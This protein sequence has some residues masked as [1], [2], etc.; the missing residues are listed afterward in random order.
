M[1]DPLGLEQFFPIP[2]PMM[3]IV[4]TD[5]LC[6]I[7]P[8]SIYE[9]LLE[10]LNKLT[11]RIN[12]LIGQCRARGWYSAVGN[13]DEFKQGVEAADG[14]LIPLQ[15][16][17]HFA[18]AGVGLDK[19]IAWFPLDVVVAALKQLVEQR[20]IIKQIIFEVSGMADVMRGQVDPKEKLGQT[21]IKA[22]W[23]GL[24]VQKKQEEVARF[25]RDLFRLKAEVM[26]KKFSM[27]TLLAMTG[28]ELQTQQEKQQIQATIQQVQMAVQAGA[29]PQ[30]Q[31]MQLAEQHKDKLQ[32]L[33]QPS[34]EEV[35]Q[36]L[37]SDTAR[38]YQIDIESDSH[39]RGDVAR[40]QQQMAMFIQGTAAFVGAVG[41]L[42]QQGAM[43]GHIAIE[44]FN[45]FARHYKL[46]KQAEDALD[47]WA[48]ETKNMGAQQKPDPQAEAAKAKA[49]ADKQKARLDVQT[50]QAEH[51]MKMQ[52]MQGEAALGQAKI[53]QEWQRVAMDGQRMQNEMVLAQQQ[54]ALQQQMAPQVVVQ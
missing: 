49:E 4:S 5:T 18:T 51:G 36:L 25:V 47:A 20:E 28:I 29:M 14:E 3:A 12:S 6:P 23:G 15:G 1:D 31:A 8:Y 43:P 21:Q 10:E 35:E 48:D 34:F 24:R 2:R 17:E 50:K 19:A 42:V 13:M 44:I 33:N 52:E 45:A 40:I 7:T 38:G 32:Q 39:I 37:R 53:E 26:A 9:E 54:A 46:G 41:P 30:Q 16:V 27:Q 11:R 22:Q